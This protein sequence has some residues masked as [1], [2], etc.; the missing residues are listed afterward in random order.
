MMLL[1]LLWGC[2]HADPVKT[3]LP[4]QPANHAA[5]Q[6]ATLSLADAP[7]GTAQVRDLLSARHPTDLPSADVLAEHNAPASLQ[8]LAVHDTHLL[9]R[10]RA[11]TAL[12]AFPSDSVES[13]CADAAK[14]TQPMV[15][16]AAVRCLAGMGTPT[17]WSVVDGMASD[18]DPR[19]VHAIEAA[20]E[21]R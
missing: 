7:E 12:A 20:S 15:R 11:L 16:A 4:S 21:L 1:T 19:V 13:T 18:T 2:A 8:W 10:Q 17:A 5:Q 14:H 6:Q 9:Q 3:T